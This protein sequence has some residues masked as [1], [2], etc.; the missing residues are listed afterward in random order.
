LNRYTIVLAL[1]VL[2]LS[3]CVVG[4]KY[5]R[6]ELKMPEAY[7]GQPVPVT[8]DTVLLSW[9]TFFKEPA[10]VALIDKALA[11]NNDVSVA[12][13]TM[14]QM[15]LNYKQSKLGLLP[16]LDLVK[17]LAER[18]PERAIHRNAVPG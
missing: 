11:K 14:Q 18:I 12:V 15:D 1:P 2:L 4:K 16:T 13:L 10:L 17:K 7:R 8:G 9:K 3:A 6:E 5:N